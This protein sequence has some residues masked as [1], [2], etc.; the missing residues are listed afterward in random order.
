M[1]V[2]LTAVSHI[3]N[4]YNLFSIKENTRYGGVF[5]SLYLRTV[6]VDV[7]VNME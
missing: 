5:I 4:L 3:S 6:G 2:K 1:N 7:V